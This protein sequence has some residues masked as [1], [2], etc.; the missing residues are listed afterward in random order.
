MKVEDRLQAAGFHQ[1]HRED[2]AGA[3]AS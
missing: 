2:G 3:Q 1:G